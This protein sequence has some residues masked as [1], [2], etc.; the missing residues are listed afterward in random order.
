MGTGHLPPDARLGV[1]D[2]GA[3]A[4]LSNRPVFDLVGLVTEGEVATGQ[5]GK[6]HGTST[7][8]RCPRDRLPTHFRRVPG[9]VGHPMLF[10]QEL[11]RATVVDQSILGARP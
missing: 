11:A 1:N 6:A 2:A 5:R 3:L 9:M 8:S 10:G 7:T 4:Y